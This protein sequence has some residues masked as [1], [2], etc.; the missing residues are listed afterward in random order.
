MHTAAHGDHGYLDFPVISP[1]PG[2]DFFSSGWEGEPWLFLD[3]VRQECIQEVHDGKNAHGEQQP[4][5]K[6]T[7]SKASPGL[8]YGS[9]SPTIAGVAGHNNSESRA[10]HDVNSLANSRTPFMSPGIG[11]TL[12]MSFL[13]DDP[14]VWGSM[15]YG[16]DENDSFPANTRA[17][18]G[19]SNNTMEAGGN[20]PC[21]PCSARDAYTDGRGANALAIALCNDL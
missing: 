11:P 9:M 17:Y 12:D 15:Q 7:R 21:P 8:A 10:M 5:C 20:N 18:A 13:D 1:G 19:D 14:L 6:G 4:V 3:P 2:I 16:G